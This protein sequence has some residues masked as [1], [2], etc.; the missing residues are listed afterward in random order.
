MQ[1]VDFNY[2]GGMTVALPPTVATTELVATAT[3]GGAVTFTSNTP[4]VC[5][6]SG[7]TLSL[8][9]AG[10]CSVTASQAGGNGY[11]PASSRQLF[12]IPK[13][14]SALVFRNP[15]SQPLDK[16]P[17]Q[18]AATS[19]VGL[20]T[21]FASKT[22]DVCTVSGTTLTKVANGMCTITATAQGDDH[23]ATITV[24]KNIPIGTATAATLTFLSGYKDADN[25]KEGVI[26]R[27]GNQWWCPEA[28]DRKVSSDGRSYTYSVTWGAAPQPSDWDYNY[29]P[30]FFLFAPGLAT[31]DLDANSGWPAGDF[32]PGA[33]GLRIDAQAALKFNLAQ[34]TE[35]F[36][37]ANNQFNVE[38]GISHFNS[39]DGKACHV[40]LKATVQPTA[41]AADYSIGL[42][43]KFALGETCGLS[44]L[45]V[46]NELQDYA[47]SEIKFSAV[48]PN[49]SS[50]YKTQF[51]LT[52][53]IVFQ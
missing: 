14:K 29:A 40:T 52:G 25:S 30:Q 20:P 44:G 37:S 16:T 5:S 42:K 31:T 21:S 33:A 53:P 24:D 38:L 45:D 11:A 22:P 49:G 10:E 41:A 2:P 50:G 3:G 7:T 4:D 12:V 34:N 51:T 35:W 28:C 48:Q 18:L 1:A 19:A 39:K 6:V 36:S 23:Y 15:G 27:P 46:W 26:G 8:L 17:V 9:K 43:D 13:I 47:I 32:R